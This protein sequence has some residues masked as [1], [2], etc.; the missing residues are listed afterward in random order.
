MA[1]PAE[2][3]IAARRAEEGDSGSWEPELAVPEGDLAAIA[4]VAVPVTSGTTS[5]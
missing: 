5:E 2:A 1:R 3:T 4:S